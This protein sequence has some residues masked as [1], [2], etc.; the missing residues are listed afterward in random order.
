MKLIYFKPGEM[1]SRCIQRI[2]NLSFFIRYLQ[3]INYTFSDF[4]NSSV[5]NSINRIPLIMKFSHIDEETFNQI[6]LD[7][8]QW[9]CNQIYNEIISIFV[10]YMD[11]ILHM[12]EFLLGLENGSSALINKDASSDEIEKVMRDAFME[13]RKLTMLSNKLKHMVELKY[14]S[15]EDKNTFLN[16][17]NSRNAIEHWHG[18]VNPISYRN[19]TV[20]FNVLF[21]TFKFILLDHTLGEGSAL[22]QNSNIET[23]DNKEIIPV[24][25]FYEKKLQEGEVINI[26]FDDLFTLIQW[27]IKLIK[28]ID[29]SIAIKRP[30]L[31]Q[32]DLEK[33]I[34]SSRKDEKK[35]D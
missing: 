11:E 16:L 2:D 26:S 20:E 25:E 12:E 4:E 14:I 10:N 15:E 9:G 5:V 3:N 35:F 23:M 28:N 29:A 1:A 7:F 13:K 18:H 17:Y 22:D 34:Q 31:N 21:P 24:I 19:D 32:E 33:L 30:S 27:I 8:A 6:G